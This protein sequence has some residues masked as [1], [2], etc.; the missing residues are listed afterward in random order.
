M[1]IINVTPDSFSDGGEFA[2]MKSDSF[3][4]NLDKILYKVES[5][6]KQGASLID[7][8][9][10]STR[11]GALSVSLDN[12][13][14]RTIPV[15]EAIKRN[16]DIRL[17]IDTSS[18][19]VMTEAIAA[20]VEMINDVRALS[21]PGAIEVAVNS[22]VAI[23]LMH[24][25]GQPESMQKAFHYKNVVSDVSD[26]LRAR[27]AACKR[28]GDINQ[29]LLIDPGFGF[30]KSIQ[31]NY[32]LL[33]FLSSF[34]NLGYPVL[35]GISRKSMIGDVV[36]RP[37]EQRVHGS[38][39]ATALAINNG[40]SIIRTHDVAATMDVIRVHCAYKNA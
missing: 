8:G 11:P 23:C 39:A 19:I 21:V 24:M 13:L 22:N 7:I 6:V 14:E 30:G 29:R 35:V 18:P 33:K 5:F 40:A 38:V 31:H 25:M 9:G 16:L 2:K 17:S 20:G 15:I 27:I 26:F 36:N 12:E 32:R 34:K 10:E 4:V 37:T 3:E 1:G 28:V